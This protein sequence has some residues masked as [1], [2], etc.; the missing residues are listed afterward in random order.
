MDINSIGGRHT[1]A[2]KMMVTCFG[3]G[4]EFPPSAIDVCDACGEFIC[5][6]C[7]DDHEDDCDGIEPF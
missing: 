4:F 7:R 5:E 3:C 1:R 2:G 6:V